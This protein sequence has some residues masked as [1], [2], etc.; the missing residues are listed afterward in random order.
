MT[1]GAQADDQALVGAKHQLGSI[2]I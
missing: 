2:T 1:A